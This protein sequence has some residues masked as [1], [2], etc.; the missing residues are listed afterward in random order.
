LQGVK[1]K[2]VQ[3]RLGTGDCKVMSDPSNGPAKSD[4][5]EMRGFVY[6]NAILCLRIIETHIVVSATSGDE[7]IRTSGSPF[8]TT[9]VFK[10]SPIVHSGTS[11]IIVFNYFSTV[12]VDTLVKGIFCCQTIWSSF[13]GT[14]DIFMFFSS[15]LNPLTKV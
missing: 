11:P 13:I 5:A 4:L 9:L 7:R 10:T 15:T 12:L 3:N 2:W 8:R 1:E 6:I 14:L